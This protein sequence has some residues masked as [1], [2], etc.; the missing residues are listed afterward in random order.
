VPDLLTDLI[1]AAVGTACLIGAWIAW[2]RLGRRPPAVV[3]AVL[4]VAAV[5]HAV[6]SLA[7]G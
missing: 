3:V 6:W 1:E 7:T 4:G 5:G 2:F